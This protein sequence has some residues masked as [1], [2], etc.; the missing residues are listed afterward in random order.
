MYFVEVKRTTPLMIIRFS[1]ILSKFFVNDNI[2]NVN[3]WKEHIENTVTI[4]EK[5]LYIRVTA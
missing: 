3:S 4:Y 1:K 2:S 5:I